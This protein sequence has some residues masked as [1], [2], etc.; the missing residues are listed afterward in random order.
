MTPD[1]TEG[2]LPHYDDQWHFMAVRQ[3]VIALR[4]WRDG[5][6]A[7][8]EET[9]YT[10]LDNPY[11]DYY[12][13]DFYEQVYSETTCSQA[14]IGILAPMLEGVFAAE[15]RC[16]SLYFKGADRSHHRWKLA[17]ENFWDP[18]QVSEDGARKKQPDLGRGIHQLV[19][20]LGIQNYFPNDLESVCD[21]IFVYRNRSLHLG[22]EWPEVERMKFLHLVKERGWERWFEYSTSDEKPWMFSMS[23]T[24]VDHAI[25]TAELVSNGFEQIR[26]VSW[27][28]E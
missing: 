14:A 23:D 21:A 28:A 19:V 17:K 25:R 15:F 24:F 11:R 1:P 22:L 18:H 9:N 4:S 20:A 16:L 12:G 8:L 26:Q 7:R 5:L 2:L 27:R 10:A 6:T 13:E 3:L